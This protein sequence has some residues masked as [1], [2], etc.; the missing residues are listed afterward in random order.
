MIYQ[1]TSHFELP[2]YFR[3]CTSMLYH[4]RFQKYLLKYH[5]KKNTYLSFRT[6]ANW[7]VWSW[8]H[9]FTAMW[10]YQSCKESDRK[11]FWTDLQLH[12]TS[13]LFHTLSVQT[14]DVFA[15]EIHFKDFHLCVLNQVTRFT[16]HLKLCWH[17]NSVLS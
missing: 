8:S 14:M 9:Y 13:V 7:N 12:L 5:S 2:F 4:C 11:T 16:M 10:R 3:F 6:V 15:N 17:P 1:F